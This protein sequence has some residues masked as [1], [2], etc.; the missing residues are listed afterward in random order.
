V[1]LRIRISV[2]AASQIHRA[3]EWW[4]ANRGSAPGAVR[5]DILSALTL[6]AQH[7]GI[8]TAYRGSRVAG[9]RRLLVSRIGY[10][11]YYRATAESLDVLAIW[12]ASRGSQ[13]V[14]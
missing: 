13:P 7:P 8:G 10:F 4:A 9:A 5:D 11:I 6:L 2:R 14:L 1:A 12:H 3:A